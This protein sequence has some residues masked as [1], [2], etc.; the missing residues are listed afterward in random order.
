MSLHVC[1]NAVSVLCTRYACTNSHVGKSARPEMTE[2]EQRKV[3]IIAF[4]AVALVIFGIIW[5]VFSQLEAE[6]A[7]DS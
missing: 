5:A 7:K 3:T 1:S 4:S 2:A 6:L